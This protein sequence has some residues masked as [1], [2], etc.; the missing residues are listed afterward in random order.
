AEHASRRGAETYACY[1][2]SVFAQQSW[3]QT[4]PDV[5][6]ERL[7]GVIQQVLQAVSVSPADIDLV[8]PHGTGTQLS[9]GYEASSLKQAL[10][11]AADKAVA[12]GFKPYV[13]HMLAA[14]G[15][16]ETICA[17]L[18]FKHGRI[19]PTPGT[20]RGVKSLGVPLVTETTERRV[21]TML[22]LSTG[23]TGH[24]AASIFSRS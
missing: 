13:G 19:P 16:A 17:L 2:G 9:D 7:R 20:R 23:F 11:G 3:K 10:N 15:I 6:A 14:S 12:T 5:R 4:I 8:V 24:D 1:R 21:D 22:K 18:T